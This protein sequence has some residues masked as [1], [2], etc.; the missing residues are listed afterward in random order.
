MALPDLITR[1]FG[2]AERNFEYLDSNAMLTGTAAGGGLSGTYPNPTVVSASGN[3]SVGG[4][5]SIPTTGSSGGLLIGGDTNLFRRAADQLATNDVLAFVRN[6][7]GDDMIYGIV[8]AESFAR[9]VMDTDGKMYFGAGTIA[10]DVTLYRN[11]ADVLRTDDSFYTLQLVARPGGADQV[12][13]GNIAGVA[14]IEF[15]G[16]MTITR[17]AAGSLK[18]NGAFQATNTIRANDSSAS[19]VQ[20]GDF[21][22]VP[23]IAFG[24]A[25][26]TVIYR[27]AAN[28]VKTDDDLLVGGNIGFYG[29]SP[30]A[31]PTVTGSR[32]GNAALASLLTGLAGLGLLTDSST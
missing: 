9:F 5:L 14:G 20:I 16:D 25:Q 7:A 28:Q 11:S 18:V 22:G 21:G 23:A 12:Q 19:E 1:D 26:D 27:G 32:G 31:K 13:A 8:G 2:A 29:T 3:V 17:P 6:A 30:A 4:Q 10:T 24:S 15:G